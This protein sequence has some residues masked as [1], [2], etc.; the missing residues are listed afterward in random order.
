MMF[1]NSVFKTI[2][3]TGE[4]P[5]V[6]SKLKKYN[7]QL[8][9]EPGKKVKDA[10]EIAYRY[11]A[12]NYRNEYLYKNTIINN[13]LLGRHSLR[14]ATMLNEFKVGGSIADSLI[15]NGS[16]TV[17][18]IKTELDTPDKLQKQLDDYRK[19]FARIYLVTHHT[20]SEYYLQF[21]QGTAVGLLSL[22]DRFNL[23]CIKEAEDYY[24]GLHNDT[25]MRCLRKNEYLNIIREINGKIPEVSNIR[26]FR[27]CISIAQQIEPKLLHGYVLQQLRTRVLSDNENLESERLPKEIKHICLCIDP[28]KAGYDNIFSF[29]N[30]NL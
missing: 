13:I 24:G 14:T 12:K 20:L 29:L 2:A 26:L 16:S 18:E 11:L 9:I 1:S 21:I 30:L 8:S 6:F 23:T 10:L 19:A 7:T 15:I 28:S 22:S 5:Y 25:M 4:N 3:E 17:Y 27:E